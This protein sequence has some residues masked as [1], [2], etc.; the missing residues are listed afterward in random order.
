[1]VM[2]NQTGMNNVCKNV[3]GYTNSR[4]VGVSEIN[5]RVFVMSLSWRMDEGCLIVIYN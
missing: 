5:L 4:C 2:E 3:I 1:M